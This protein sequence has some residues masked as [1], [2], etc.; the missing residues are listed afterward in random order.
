MRIAIAIFE[1]AEELDF[2]PAVAGAGAWRF[3]YPDVEVVMVGENTAPV[4]C[5]RGV[6]VAADISWDQLGDVDVLVYPAAAARARSSATTRSAGRD[7]RELAGGARGAAEAARLAREGFGVWVW[8]S[9][10]VC[11]DMGR[12][13][14]GVV[15]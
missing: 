3:L 7:R 10:G 6:R 15:G 2:A 5:A 14:A 13:Q 1:G 11:G 8:L 4:T 12:M 9:L